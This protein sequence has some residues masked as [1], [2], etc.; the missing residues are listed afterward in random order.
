VRSVEE[1]DELLDRCD[2]EASANGRPQDVQL[3]PSDGGGTLGVVVGDRRTVLNHMP[4]DDDPP[5]T[6]SR[7]EENVDR[8]LTF[9]V[10]GDHHCEARWRSTVPLG[11]GREVARAFMRSGRLDDRVNWEE[12]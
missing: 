7:G 4:A 1:L 6:T 3:T 8:V 9:Y 5:Y 10:A 11:V 12:V 2:A